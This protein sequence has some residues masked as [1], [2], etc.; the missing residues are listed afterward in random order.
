MYPRNKSCQKG[1]EMEYDLKNFD[2]K[3]ASK[4]LHIKYEFENIEH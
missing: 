4:M 1:T 3:R 2:F